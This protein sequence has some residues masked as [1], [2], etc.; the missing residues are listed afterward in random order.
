MIQWLDL[1]AFTAEG[2]GSIPGGRTKIPGVAW[3]SQ[4]KKSCLFGVTWGH[5]DEVWMGT[6]NLPHHPLAPPLPSFLGLHF[7]GQLCIT[8]VP[9]FL[10]PP[11][12]AHEYSSIR[13]PTACCQLD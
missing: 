6:E 13:A 2:L 5:A 7:Q 9:S 10:P 8:L 1:C 3:Y 4:K 12:L 11:D